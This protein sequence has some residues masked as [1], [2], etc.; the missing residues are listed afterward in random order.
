MIQTR[1]IKSQV[2]ELAEQL[3]EM[4]LTAA[5]RALANS[6]KQWEAGE[7]DSFDLKDLIHRFHQGPAREL[8]VR[9]DTRNAEANVAYAIVKGTLD[10]ATVAPEIL[11]ELER[12][13]S[14]MKRQAA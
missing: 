7:V 14:Y 5:L 11:T 8:Y 12:W 9:Y 6:F 3:H 4:E 2:R 1:R 13:I 10:P